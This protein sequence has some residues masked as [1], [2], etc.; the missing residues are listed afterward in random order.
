MSATFVDM[1]DDRQ[2]LREWEAAKAE[3]ER[4]RQEYRTAREFQIEGWFGHTR[5][6][7][8][9]AQAADNE[10]ILRER[11]EGLVMDAL[12]RESDAR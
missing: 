3:A 6:A 10:A 8:L 2:A 1:T 5:A 7:I 11:Y 12:R 9:Y 4:L